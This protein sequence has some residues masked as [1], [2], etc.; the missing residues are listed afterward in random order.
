MDKNESR[1]E[2]GKNS[3][4]VKVLM[5]DCEQN[6]TTH[7]HKYMHQYSLHVRIALPQC[8]PNSEQGKID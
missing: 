8:T 1:M 4:Q 2:K 7:A 6:T 3:K 5:T